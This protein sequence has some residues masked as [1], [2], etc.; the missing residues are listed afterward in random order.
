MF[1]CSSIRKG[2]STPLLFNFFANHHFRSFIH[3]DDLMQ[4]RSLDGRSHNFAFCISNHLSDGILSKLLYMR[5]GILRLSI[6]EFHDVRMKHIAE[7][8]NQWTEE[9]VSISFLGIL[10]GYR[11]IELVVAGHGERESMHEIFSLLTVSL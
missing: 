6:F 11:A 7:I 9:D 3:H 5:I 4:L 10:F 8:I 1:T 2:I